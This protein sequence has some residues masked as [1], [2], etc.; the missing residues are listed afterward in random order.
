MIV[1]PET[2]EIS[3]F[4]ITVH[5][6]TGLVNEKGE[7]CYGLADYHA[8][9]I[10]LDADQPK[11]L[12]IATFLHEA[13]HFYDALLELK[14]SHRS[15]DL[16]GQASTQLLKTKKGNILKTKATPYEY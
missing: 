3:C 10:Y 6:V 9:R 13:N 4:T 12:M 11:E 15:I 16:L 5:L 7:E 2:F 8:F 14:L 1:I